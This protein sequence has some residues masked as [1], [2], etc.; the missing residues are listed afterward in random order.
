[1]T[2][3]A[4][5][6]DRSAQMRLIRSTDTKPEV[7]LRS[8]IHKLGY[9]YRLH[10]AKL[11]GKPDLV[12]SSRKKRFMSTDVFGIDIPD[13]KRPECPNHGLSTG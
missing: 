13:V 11:P 2:D 6:P 4:T 5:D 7:K 10:W 9:R 1:M 12:F 3:E 8:Y